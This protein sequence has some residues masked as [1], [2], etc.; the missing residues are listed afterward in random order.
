LSSTTTGRQKQ[1][2]IKLHGMSTAVEFILG[3]CIFCSF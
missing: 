3:Y 2:S 1:L